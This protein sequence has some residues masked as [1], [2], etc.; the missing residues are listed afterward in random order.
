MRRALSYGEL[1]KAMDSKIDPSTVLSKVEQQTFTPLQA[2]ELRS[3]E[4]LRDDTVNFFHMILRV[5][6]EAALAA[7]LASGSS[8]IAQNLCWAFSSFFYTKLVGEAEEKCYVYARVKNWTSKRGGG[9][10]ARPAVDIFAFRWVI[11]PINRANQHWVLAVVDNAVRTIS[12]LDSWK[13]NYSDVSANLQRYIADEHLEKKGAPL[14]ALYKVVPQPTDLPRQTNGVDCGAF[15]CAFG[16]HF[17]RGLFPSSASFT[18]ANMQYWRLRIALTCLRG[19]LI[20]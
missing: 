8:G 5:R 17:S 13:G 16:E 20:D 12:I 11:M 3:N 10:S 7:A 1:D 6:G 19:D 9:A 15:I 14:P 18:Q 2:R 4:W